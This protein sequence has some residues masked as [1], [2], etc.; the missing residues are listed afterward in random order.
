MSTP[1]CTACGA[2]ARYIV[3]TRCLTCGNDTTAPAPDFN[4]NL[5]AL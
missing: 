5:G 3:R 2:A 1:Y 4:F